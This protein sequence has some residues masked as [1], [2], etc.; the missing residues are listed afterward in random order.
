MLVYDFL[1]SLEQSV[2]TRQR[3][4]FH[5]ATSREVAS[6]GPDNVNESFQ[7]HYALGFTQLLPEIVYQNARNRKN[8]SGEQ[9]VAA[10]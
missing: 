9:R 1:L 2:G 3:S 8:V 10:E 4:W 6:S 5:Y 7:L